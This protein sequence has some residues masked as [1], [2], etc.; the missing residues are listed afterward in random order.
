MAKYGNL[1]WDKIKKKF[2]MCKPAIRLLCFS[3]FD[4]E[5]SGDQTRLVYKH[6]N[7]MFEQ[8]IVMYKV[9]NLSADEMIT[10]IALIGD[11]YTYDEALIITL[12]VEVE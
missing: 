6:S 8:M 10:Y 4:I 2:S 11:G 12:S 1:N 5:A 9:L 7:E 3:G